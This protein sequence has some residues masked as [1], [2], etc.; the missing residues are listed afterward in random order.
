MMLVTEAHES[1]KAHD[2]VAD[3]TRDFIDHQ[4]IDF[5]NFIAAWIIDVGAFDVFARDQVKCLT[6]EGGRDARVQRLL[7]DEIN[8]LAM[9]K[10]E[11]SRKAL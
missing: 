9:I 4:M 5:A 11:R 6:G 10:V 7:P 8:D 1:S 2:R 3:I